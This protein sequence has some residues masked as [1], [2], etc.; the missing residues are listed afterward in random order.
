MVLDVMGFSS[1]KIF[2][3]NY[4]GPVPLQVSLVFFLGVLTNLLFKLYMYY[5]LLMWYILTWTY[6]IGGCYLL[7]VTCCDHVMFSWEH[8]YSV[9]ITPLPI[10]SKISSQGMLEIF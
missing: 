8:Y 3:K 1:P 6:V 5:T 10:S 9:R 7:T 2:H 4:V